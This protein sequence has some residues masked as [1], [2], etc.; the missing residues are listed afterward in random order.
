M[1]ERTFECPQTTGRQL[2]AQ[3][4]GSQNAARA[5]YMTVKT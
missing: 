5:A 4:N 1:E 3:L 2:S